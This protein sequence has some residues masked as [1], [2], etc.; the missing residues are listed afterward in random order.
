MVS[1]RI[2]LAFGLLVLCCASPAVT[3]ERGK[4]LYASQCERCHKSPRDVT[5]FRGGVD[6]ETFLGELH[7]ADTRESAAAIAT[8]LKG[9]EHKR[10]T[11]RRRTKRRSDVVNDS[12]PAPSEAVPT[13]TDS[14]DDGLVTRTLKKL[15]GVANP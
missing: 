1:R 10:S 2:G 6:L 9:L 3:Q 5:T 11:D 12:E 15:L 13:N 4:T 7:H 8:Y 14:S